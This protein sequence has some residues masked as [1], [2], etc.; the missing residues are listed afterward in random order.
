MLK[1][2]TTDV[3]AGLENFYT[4]NGDGTFRLQVE[5]VVPESEVVA[6]KAKNK[7][8]REANIGLLKTNES[9]SSF[10]KVF[11]TGNVTP[12]GINARIETLAT[13]RATLLSENAVKAAH[14]RVKE[15]ETGLSTKQQKLSKLM[16]GEAVQKAGTKHGVVPTAFDDVL[17]RAESDFEVT[18]EG[19]KFRQEKLDVEGK[20]YTVDSW[21]AEQA[22]A[23]PHLFAQ[24]QG[25]SA[26]RPSKPGTA[27]T[28]NSAPKSASELIASGLNQMNSTGAAR[29]L[30]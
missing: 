3:P 25:T 22:Q 12:D 30:N 27:T 24:S 14:E 28:Q 7:E 9:L 4:D 1:Y 20:P 29:R 8:F 17:R 13:E 16:L 19:L 21:M 5:G 26:A 11:G 15:L 10:E 18:D 2:Q 23:A 6:L